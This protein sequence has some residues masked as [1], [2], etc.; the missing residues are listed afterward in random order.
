MATDAAAGSII[1]LSSW[2]QESQ[3][4]TEQ[5]PNPIRLDSSNLAKPKLSVISIIEGLFFEITDGS[6]VMTPAFSR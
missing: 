6:G 2:P 5:K 1:D 3:D 4:L